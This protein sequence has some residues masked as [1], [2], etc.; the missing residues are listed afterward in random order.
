M[1]K[2]S[3]SVLQCDKQVKNPQRDL[4][5]GIAASLSLCCGLYMIVSIVV[6]GLVPYYDINPNTPISSAFAANG[7]QWAA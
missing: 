6:V 2:L 1:F 4:P 7:M 5:I 3:N